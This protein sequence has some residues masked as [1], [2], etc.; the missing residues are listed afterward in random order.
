MINYFLQEMPIEK[1]ILIGAAEKDGLV[2]SVWFQADRGKLDQEISAEI[3]VTFLEKR[4]P[5]LKELFKQVDQYWAGKRTTFDLE[6]DLIGTEF[7]Q[8][9]WKELLRIPYGRTTTYGAIA[10]K[11]G[12]PKAA[13]AVGQAVGKNPVAL[14]VP[15]HRVIGHGGKLTGYAYGLDIKR[16]L[17]ELEDANCASD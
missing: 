6:L 8:R 17:L 7:Q 10:R 13:I 5:V 11:I 3:D 16:R 14:I 12:S 9:V 1:N 15:C 2:L 4:S